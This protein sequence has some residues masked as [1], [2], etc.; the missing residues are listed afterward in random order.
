MRRLNS[1]F[2]SDYISE[3]GL[4]AQERTYFAYV[5]LSN[6]ICYVVAEGYDDSV[7]I[8][9]ERLAVESVL[10][11]F[12]REPSIKA[13]KLK[14]YINYANDQL[15]AHSTQNKLEASIFVV[16]SDYTR[17]RHAGCGSVKLF[18]VSDN[19]LAY[20]TKTQTRYQDITDGHINEDDGLDIGEANN[21]TQYLGKDKRLNIEVSK[22]IALYENSSL[23]LMTCNAWNKLPAYSSAGAAGISPDKRGVE[24]IDA[25]EDAKSNSEFLLNLEEILL[26]VQQVQ[27]IRSYTVISVAIKKTFKEDTAKIKKRRKMLIIAGIIL[28]ALVII[29][30][31]IILVVRHND[32]V[33]LDEIKELDREGVRYSSFGNYIKALERYR[34]ADEM[35]KKLSLW[36][37]QYIREKRELMRIVRDR[38]ALLSAVDEGNNMIELKNYKSARNIFN[39]IRNEADE[40]VELGLV[41]MSRET[42]RKIDYY[43]E[44]ANYTSLGEMYDLSGLFSQALLNY[45]TALKFIEMTD[46]FEARKNLQIKITDAEKKMVDKQR[47]QFD[48]IAQANKDKADELRKEYMDLINSYKV[49]ADEAERKGDFDTAIAKYNQIAA[50]YIELG[51]T[52]ERIETNAK[53]VA[54]EKAKEQ[55]AADAIHEAKMKEVEDLTEKALSAE[56]AGNNAE[57]IKYCEQI[58]EIYKELGISLL[59]S[60][61]TKVYDWIRELEKPPPATEPVSAE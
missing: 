31:V 41:S 16:V 59:D 39:Y 27:T 6:Y 46:D 28:L 45:E 9:S 52:D 4:D 13:S 30:L 19:Q 23:V 25:Y 15:K 53:I 22:K 29:F 37:F 1:L 21:L 12:Q 50:I 2:E 33:Y 17:I 47:D 43:I 61:Y 56:R 8:K 48:V 24:I 3:K 55:G 10:S 36:N 14:K 7:D 44:A 34:A 5:P 20:E 60:Q 51:M 26:N 54:L 58:L 42:Q 38:A 49:E 11:I 18:I 40:H 57:A 32:R 35:A